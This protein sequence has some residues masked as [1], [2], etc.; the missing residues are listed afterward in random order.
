M[1]DREPPTETLEQRHAELAAEIDALN[2]LY[3]LSAQLLRP[4]ELK[5]AIELILDGSMEIL[6]ATMGDVQIYDAPSQTMKVVAHR[7]MHQD[8]ID[9]LQQ[10]ALDPDSPCARARKS[11]SRVIVEDV[12]SDAESQHHRA[13]AAAAG[14]RGMQCTPLLSRDGELLGVVSTQFPKRHRPSEHEL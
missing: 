14:Y 11:G 12:E 10:L 5:S 8:H 7:G 1:A 13:V 2:R 4:T 3:R 9:C 6:G